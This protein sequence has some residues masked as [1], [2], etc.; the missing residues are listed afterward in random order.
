MTNSMPKNFTRAFSLIEM[1]IVI[2][3]IAILETLLVIGKVTA[4]TA[5]AAARQGAPSGA[6]KRARVRA[7]APPAER[8]E[9]P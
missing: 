4:H 5:V 6:P 7:W 1:M 8:S 3:I 9:A 2:G